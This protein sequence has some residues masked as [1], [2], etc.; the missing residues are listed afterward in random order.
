MRTSSCSSGNISICETFLLSPMRDVPKRDYK[1]NNEF[2]IFEK[3][4]ELN[5]NINIFTEKYRGKRM[6]RAQMSI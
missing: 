5:S 2:K 6:S 1:Q 3:I 4:T